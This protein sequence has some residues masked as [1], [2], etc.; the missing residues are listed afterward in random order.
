M[1]HANSF[2]KIAAALCLLTL[3][4][5]SASLSPA[6]PQLVI[7]AVRTERRGPG[8]E[9]AESGQV[10]LSFDTERSA[11]GEALRVAGAHYS[12]DTRQTEPIVPPFTS[13]E[14]ATWAAEA[15]DEFIRGALGSMH[16]STIQSRIGAQRTNIARVQRTTPVGD[17]L[18][19][20]GM[21]PN[22][23]A[24]GD[25]L[26]ASTQSVL[27]V[28]AADGRSWR[29]LPQEAS[30]PCALLGLPLWSPDGRWLAFYSAPATVLREGLLPPGVE[31]VADLSDRRAWSL[32]A[33]DAST[34]ATVALAPP[35]YA[36]AGRIL[37]ADFMSWSPDS[38][39]LLFVTSANDMWASPE[40]TPIESLHVVDLESRE[41]RRLVH[42]SRSACVFDWAPDGIHVITRVGPEERWNPQSRRFDV[43]GDVSADSEL[44]LIDT[45]TGDRRVVW[46]GSDSPGIAHNLVHWSVSPDLCW[47]AADIRPIAGGQEAR[48]G[49]HIF[50][51]DLVRGGAP[52][53]VY[54]IPAHGGRIHTTGISW[55]ETDA[56]PGEP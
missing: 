2:S 18:W 14:L 42:E 11:S 52:Q 35:G 6:A 50:V 21:V 15:T 28:F 5:G 53:L 51:L 49:A 56:A 48:D 36:S 20:E 43:V 13:V 23:R 54:T 4:P 44:W 25:A 27:A 45:E 46:R 40:S 38:R 26:S 55:A 12:S 17:L 30:E 37:G 34:G 19:I 7:D 29:L 41:V 22:P 16:Q 24:A 8:A 33:W 39:Q 32:L 10:T 1:I 47:A 31:S 9:V 3:P